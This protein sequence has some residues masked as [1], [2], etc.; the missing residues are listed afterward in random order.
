MSAEG[1]P[2][3]MHGSGD[4]LCVYSTCLL[5]CLSLSLS[6]FQ[7]LVLLSSRNSLFFPQRTCVDATP[8]Y[9]NAS[10]F[11]MELVLCTALYK[12][13]VLDAH[14]KFPL[15]FPSIYR[16]TANGVPFH[17]HCAMKLARGC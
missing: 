17:Q 2:V 8:L 9:L 11:T 6:P 14:S 16:L 10:Y 3:W 7:I 5:L 4:A 13:S 1:T 12:N 15:T